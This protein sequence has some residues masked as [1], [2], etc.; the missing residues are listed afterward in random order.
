VAIGETSINITNQKLYLLQLLFSKIA[1]SKRN[2][3]RTV[4]TNST[5]PTCFLPQAA[6]DSSAVGHSDTALSS[7]VDHSDTALSS[8]V[9]HS[10]TALSSAVDHSDTALSRAVDHS[11]TALS[12]AVD[13]SDTALSSAVGHSDTP[14]QFTSLTLCRQNESSN[15]QYCLPD[16]TSQLIAKV[17]ASVLY[18]HLPHSRKLSTKTVSSHCLGQL[19]LLKIDLG[20]GPLLSQAFPFLY[21]RT[22]CSAI[23]QSM[24]TSI[25]TLCSAR[26]S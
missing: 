1:K 21:L 3:D 12:R 14:L 20:F 4:S 24:S 26:I 19:D 9:D 17:I 15:R 2:R 22:L 8:A 13:H 5:V 18:A 7:T 16:C 6:A 11:D 25:S 23:G 10:D